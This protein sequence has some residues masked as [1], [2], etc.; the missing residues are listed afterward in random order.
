MN[1]ND[2]EQQALFR[3]KCSDWLNDNAQR[4]TQTGIDNPHGNGIRRNF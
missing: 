1:F 2:T 4:K 3:A